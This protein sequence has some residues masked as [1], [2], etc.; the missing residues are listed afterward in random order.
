[1]GY[2]DEFGLEWDDRKSE[3][4][5]KRRGLALE[6]VGRQLLSNPVSTYSHPE[7]PDQL[8]AVGQISEVFYTLVFEDIDD[9]YGGYTHLVTYWRSERWEIEKTRPGR[10]KR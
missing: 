1:M 7:Y 10:K 9:D 3:I 4:C 8:R 5:Q 6:E 2:D